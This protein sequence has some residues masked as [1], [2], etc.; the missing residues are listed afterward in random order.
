MPCLMSSD[1]IAPV[2][3]FHLKP[4]RPIVVHSGPAGRETVTTSVVR[5]AALYTVS[6]AP[7]WIG[8][9][10]EPSAGGATWLVGGS[11]LVDAL[12]EIFRLSG[13]AG[14]GGASHCVGVA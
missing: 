4:P 2:L 6:V 10:P 12:N 11:L 5:P 3:L 9:P 1:M 14:G 13:S 8:S 7:C